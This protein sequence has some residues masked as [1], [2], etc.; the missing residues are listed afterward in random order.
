M[1]DD[2][3]LTTSSARVVCLEG[4]W[5][6]D[7]RQGP[8]SVTT[9]GH[10]TQRRSILASGPKA[11][12][13]TCQHPRGS[14]ELPQDRRG[15][16]GARAGWRGKRNECSKIMTLKPSPHRSALHNYQWPRRC[17]MVAPVGRCSG[18]RVGEVQETRLAI[19]RFVQ[20]ARPR[21]DAVV[22]G[23]GRSRCDAG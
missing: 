18:C 2:P 19:P 4:V 9:T 13:Y 6:A 5:T 12:P 15:E 10:T 7:S 14:G 23:S 1:K 16:N 20:R 11:A 22:S 3:R 17:I 8:R 21:C